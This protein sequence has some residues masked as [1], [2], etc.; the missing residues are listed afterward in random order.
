MTTGEYRKAIY[1]IIEEIIGGNI[2][3]PDHKRLKKAMT[4][5]VEGL[6][7]L[8]WPQGGEKQL[9]LRAKVMAKHLADGEGEEDLI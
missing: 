9:K 5:Y 4:D 3:E 2:S 8:K 1:K 7:L 6:T